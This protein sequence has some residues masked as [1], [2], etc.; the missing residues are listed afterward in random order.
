MKRE[1]V[2]KRYTVSAFRQVMKGVY[3]S[4]IGKETLDE[5]PFAYRGMEEIMNAV[6]D[7]MEITEILKPV[8]N[9]K[10]GR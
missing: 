7:T 6:A 3:S 1:D 2:K 8:Y 9:Y 4:C 5:A 10:A